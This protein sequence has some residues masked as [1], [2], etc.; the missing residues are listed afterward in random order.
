M[1]HCVDLF[2]LK[3]RLETLAVADILLIE[4]RPLPGDHFYPVQ[5]HLL[6]IIEIV[7][8]HNII[9]GIQKLYD[10]VTPDKSGTSRNKNSHILLRRRAP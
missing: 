3:N 6:C 8:N 7:R 10:R 9:S 4:C 2:L 1:D 5:D